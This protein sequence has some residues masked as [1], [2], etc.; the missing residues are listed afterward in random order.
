MYEEHAPVRFPTK[1][2]FFVAHRSS[3][4]PPLPLDLVRVNRRFVHFDPLF[5]FRPNHSRTCFRFPLFEVDH[6]QN[7]RKVPLLLHHSRLIRPGMPLTMWILMPFRSTVT[8]PPV[9][10][11]N[12]NCRPCVRLLLREKRKSCHYCPIH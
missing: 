6:E 8:W 12:F 2:F 9:N 11:F 3:F 4:L 5:L 10:P 1:C 7:P